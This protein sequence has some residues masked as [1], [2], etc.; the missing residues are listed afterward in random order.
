MWGF[1][2]SSWDKWN[3][4]SNPASCYSI[5]SVCGT[6]KTSLICE[7]TSIFSWSNCK[8]TEGLWNTPNAKYN[9][10]NHLNHNDV[11]LNQV[12]HFSNFTLAD[13]FQQSVFCPCGKRRDTLN[14]PLVLKQFFHFSTYLCCNCSACYNIISH[15]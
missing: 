2:V 15:V 13:A 5:I 9:F 6:D 1:V 7:S 4:G 3:T 8:N 14:S 12:I 11:F 10:I